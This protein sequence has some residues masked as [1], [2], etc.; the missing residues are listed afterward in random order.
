V[1]ER[2]DSVPATASAEVGRARAEAQ[3]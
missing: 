1:R 3:A 2:L